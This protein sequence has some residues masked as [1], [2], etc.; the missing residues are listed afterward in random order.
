MR[1]TDWITVIGGGLAGAEA[2]WQIAQRGVRVKLYEMRPRK[3]T[4]AHTTGYLAEL[5]CSNSLGA[6]QDD[7]APGLLKREM[8]ML[9]SL[10]LVCAERAA[11]P[12][13]SALAVDRERFALEVTRRI[14]S[15]PLIEVIR[16]E[17]IRIP[18]G[19]S[20]IA[21][22][23]LTSDALAAEIAR[24]TGS[25]YLYFWDAIAPIVTLD[26]VDLTIAFH[27]SR[28]GKTLG[29]RSSDARPALQPTDGDY[30]N[31][32][33]TREEYY[34]FVEALT[35][36]ETATLRDFELRDERFFEG[37]LPIEVMARRGKDAL[38]FG[39]MRPVGIRDPRTGRRPFAVVQLR[40]DNIAGTLYNLVGF[41]TNLKFPEQDRV[42]RMIPGL[43]HAEFVRYGQMHRNTF[44]N[45]PALL[46]ATLKLKDAPLARQQRPIPDPRRAIFFAGQIVGVEGYV[47]N[48]A[49]G[50]LAGV[51]A[52]RAL[53]G[54]P[55]VTLPPTTMLGALCH[56][57]AH[58][59][60]KHFQPMKANFGILPPLAHPPRDKRLRGAAYAERARRDL[61]TAIESQGILS[62][63]LAPVQT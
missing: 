44:I 11:V 34:A 53:R 45:A 23:P 1:E 51:N 26:S 55:L 57:I 46:S 40:Q 43:Q 22:G 3:M 10:I 38:A 47:G 54:E 4:P 31:C 13:G 12:A 33:M 62:D 19:V 36:A 60:P 61:Q 48:A 2:A 29:S 28:Y 5:V 52:V 42:L 6:D 58:A 24:L 35:T 32:P 25:E 20:V 37:C 41:Q 56:Y 17:A 14:E 30:I 39:P 50:L 8:R 59:D 16:E 9:G 27:A 63:M 21:S 7:K 15:H 49:T 18:E